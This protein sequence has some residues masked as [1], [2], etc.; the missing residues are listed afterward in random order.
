MA[1]GFENKTKLNAFSSFKSHPNIITFLKKNVLG[2]SFKNR[3]D[4][5]PRKCSLEGT[6]SVKCMTVL[7]APHPSPHGGI[8]SQGA[9]HRLYHN[10]S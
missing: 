2:H 1:C 8:L 3:I 10:K 6:D 5:N 7:L 4:I 9:F